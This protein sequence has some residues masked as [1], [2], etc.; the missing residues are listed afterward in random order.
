MISSSYVL[1]QR[2][3]F[4]NETLGLSYE[5]GNRKKDDKCE[6]EKCVPEKERDGEN[7]QK[8]KH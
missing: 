8:I 5:L 4:V 1:S 3:L 2:Y 6:Q 7:I